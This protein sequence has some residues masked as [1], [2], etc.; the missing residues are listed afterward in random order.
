MAK[1]RKTASLKT[2]RENISHIRKM[3]S[4]LEATKIS[5]PPQ[6]KDFKVRRM[7]SRLIIDGKT[8]KPAD[9]DKLKGIKA[10]FRLQAIA[11][12]EKD[13]QK[14]IWKQEQINVREGKKRIRKVTELTDFELELARQG[15]DFIEDEE[16]ELFNDWLNSGSPG[17]KKN[18]FYHVYG[19]DAIN[20][21]NAYGFAKWKGYNSIPE[22]IAM[23]AEDA[24]LM[25]LADKMLERKGS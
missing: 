24:A 7:G 11:E 10:E 19:A 20:R 22:F 5:I 23:E 8:F 4:R 3:I 16:V 18:E 12:L 2:I 21:G 1:P 13:L 17:W 9:L 14:N 15:V 25:Q 6:G